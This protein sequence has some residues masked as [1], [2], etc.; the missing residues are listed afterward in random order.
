MPGDVDGLVVRWLRGD[1]RQQV[2]VVCEANG[3]VGSLLRISSGITSSSC[4][5]AWSACCAKASRT[6]PH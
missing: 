5:N 1:S 2:V 3:M 6:P 4:G